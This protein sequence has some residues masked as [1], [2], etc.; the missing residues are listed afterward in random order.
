MNPSYLRLEFF[1]LTIVLFISEKLAE[2]SVA[3]E[4][5]SS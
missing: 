3:R 2:L 4:L 5:F 1:F